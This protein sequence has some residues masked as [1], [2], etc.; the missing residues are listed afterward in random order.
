MKA[1]LA[2]LAALME[3]AHG[4]DAAALARAQARVEE[5]RRRAEALRD[6]VAPPDG[7]DALLMAAAD[8]HGLWRAARRRALLGELA[9]AMAELEG[10][11]ARAQR[12]FGRARAAEALAVRAATERGGGRRGD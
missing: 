7:A 9:L 11:R 4:A 12:S 1:D 5:L 8:R 3:A 10:V 6:P 2:G